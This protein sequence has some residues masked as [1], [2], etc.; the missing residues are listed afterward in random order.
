ML[1][2]EDHRIY[3]HREGEFLRGPAVR[4]LFEGE[5]LRAFANEP[6]AVALF[7]N[8]VRVATRSMKYHRPRGLYCLAGRCMSC[9]ARVDGMPNVRT[10][11][12]PC[13]DGMTVRR[14]N[15]V[16]HATDD[17]LRALD[18][19][20]SKRLN[21]HELFTS[22]PW[23]NQA[24]QKAVLTFAGTGDLPDA[25]GPVPPLRSRKV[26]VLVIGA[27]PGGLAAALAAAQGGCRVLLV[28]DAP[29][30]GGHLVGWP[31]P[32]TDALDGPAYVAS[33][34]EYLAAAGVEVLTAAECI[35]YFHEGFW[36][37]HHGDGL[38][39]VEA[40]RTIVATGAYDQ[41]PLFVNNDLP[42]IFSTR[43]LLKLVNRYGVRPADA[44]T[45][46]GTDDAA[47]ALAERLPEIGVRV[48][49]LVTEKNQ[50]EGDADR[51]ELVQSRGVPIFLGHRVTRA[52]GTMRLRGLRFEPCGGGDAVDARSDLVG[53]S[54]PPAPSWELAAQ[55]GARATYRPD[56][57][58]FAVEADSCGRTS[59]DALFVTG[60]MQGATTP[61]RAARRGRV[62]GLAVA[63][64]LHRSDEKQAQLDALLEG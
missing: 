49:G 50:I 20:F 9:L 11:H 47:L 25:P 62:T 44:C 12:L 26:E 34:A 45:I 55:A 16:P 59:S 58:G 48:T 19:V 3:T 2:I 8:G 36:A 63:L 41:P 52:L 37:V 31:L 46:I 4:I 56:L 53:V 30:L 7:A 21:Y 40:G 18:F 5:R 29:E 6:V 1:R 13:R 24:L 35:G 17:A 54:V 14:E 23:L 51:A 27:G 43:G 60:E 33:M 42:N 64:D 28:E 22:P 61:S 10:C 38:V 39:L 57:G 15:G 32:V